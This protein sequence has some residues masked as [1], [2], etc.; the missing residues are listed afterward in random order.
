MDRTT[1]TPQPR[2]T[3]KRS[4]EKMIFNEADLLPGAGTKTVIVDVHEPVA[5]EEMDDAANYNSAMELN[6]VNTTLGD[7]GP[8]TAWLP[9]HPDTKATTSN[10]GPE[11]ASTFF[12]PPAREESFET[13]IEAP[14]ADTDSFLN[15]AS[16]NPI[17]TTLLRKTS[18][19]WHGFA[20]M[21]AG[22]MN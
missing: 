11:S 15:T 18:N 10:G 12:A 6:F 20:S 19:E 17:E 3:K 14:R 4:R 2:L 16:N 22:R 21:D 5:F 7:M 9:T 1:E 13:Y 8:P